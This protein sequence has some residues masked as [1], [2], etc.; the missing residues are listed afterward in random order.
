MQKERKIC[1]NIGGGNI[2][3]NKLRRK[4][5]FAGIFLVLLISYLQDHK[6]DDNYEAYNSEEGPIG[7]YEDG[8]IYIGDDDY[9]D[10]INTNEGDVLVEDLRD[11][12]DPNVLIRESYKITD[13]DKRN[14]ILEV[15]CEYEKNNPS[16]WNR[17]IESMRLEW[18]IHNFSHDMDYKKDHSDD[19]DLN[20]EDEEDYDD[21]VLRKL[22]RL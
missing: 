15:L 20:N 18:F 19:V 11:T 22:F 5:V 16:E 2:K 17:S 8:Y 21:K 1:N 10:S 14:Q 12:D 7:R 13:K 6:Y 9:L 3:N 4:L